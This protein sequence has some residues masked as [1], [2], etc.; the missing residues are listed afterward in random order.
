MADMFGGARRMVEVCDTHDIQLTF[1]H[2]YR[3]KHAF[4]VVKKAIDEGAIGD[5]Q[6][7]SYGFPDLFTHGTHSIDL[8]GYYNDE[9]PAEWVVGQIDYRTENRHR[10]THVENQAFAMWEYDNGVE[11]L[12]STQHG[13][14]LLDERGATDRFDCHYGIHNRVDGT[15]GTIL[16]VQRYADEGPRYVT[17]RGSGEDWE[18]IAETG[19]VHSGDDDRRAI[20]DVLDAYENGTDSELSGK[21]ALKTTEILF[22]V[23]ESSRRRG[24]VDLPL[25]IDDHPLAAMVEAGDLDPAPSDE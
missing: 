23:W 18:R 20:V 3:F 9:R 22:G 10:G 7:V 2:Q 21:N 12:G 1:H 4:R 24:R 6:R 13:Q 19:G 16:V 15:Q 25:E 8:C 14:Y 17:L 11:G 5:L